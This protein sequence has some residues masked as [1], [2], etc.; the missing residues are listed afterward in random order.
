MQTASVP[1]A[2]EGFSAAAI[3]GEGREG[4]GERGGADLGPYSG[5]T[6][7]DLKLANVA[8]LDDAFQAAREAQRDWARRPPA[9]RAAV[10]RA[11]ADVMGARKQ[12]VVDWL[13]HQAGGTG[14]K[15]G[16]GGGWG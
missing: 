8:D 11:A 6:L 10:M 5:E 16:V 13:V 3:A 15:A 14:A 2:Y 12:E 9:A 7:L 1:A 4:R